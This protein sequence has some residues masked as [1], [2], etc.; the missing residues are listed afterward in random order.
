MAQRGR[1]SALSLL[2]VAVTDIC[3]RPQPP[4]ELTDEEATEWAAI[5]NSTPPDYFNQPNQVILKQF[6][7]H[8][9]TARRLAEMIRACGTEKFDAKF[10]FLLREARGESQAICSCLRALRL[11]HLSVKPSSRTAF[12]SSPVPKPW[13]T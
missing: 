11:T 13:E 12:A 1:K 2:E 5:V 9:V 7:K 3:P 10:R 6:C 8:V 4:A